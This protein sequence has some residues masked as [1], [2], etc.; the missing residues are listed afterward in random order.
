[1]RASTLV[2]VAVIA[3]GFAVLCALGT[4]QVYRLQWKENLIE[5]VESRIASPPEPL[6][7][8]EDEWA[9]TGDVDFQPVSLSGIFDHSAEQYYYNTWKGQAGWNVYTP[10]RL[11]GG[12]TVIIN[13]GFVPDRLRDPSTRPQGLVEDEQPITGLARNPP[14]AKPNSF[15]PD[16]E[17]G[18]G[19]FFW[20][21]LDEMAAA[22]GLEEYALVPF[23]VDAGGSETP[24]GWPLGGTTRVSFPNNHLQYA[25]T[26]YGLALALLAVG[27][28]FLRSRRSGASRS[29]FDR[30]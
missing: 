18:K 26:W 11:A 24:G 29:D 17:P 5:Q 30:N 14:P 8:I 3:A 19:I 9:D 27:I 12:R 15:M 20:K 13:R 4:W 1:L 22:A 10:L 21:S 2:I 6:A 16:N 23:F 25:I 7:Q 28:A